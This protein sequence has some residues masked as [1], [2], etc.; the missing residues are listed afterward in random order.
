M[1]SER[2]ILYFDFIDPLSRLMAWELALPE[3]LGPDGFDWHPCE[4]RPPPTPLTTV[5]DA[6]VAERWAA[7]GNEDPL[8]RTWAPPVLVPWTRKAHEFM[9]HASEEG[10]AREAREAV[11]D[12]YLVEGRD[13]G[14]VDV[15]VAIG[16]SLGLDPG[17]TRPVLDV[18]R[19]GAEAAAAHEEAL[20]RGV[21]T[22]PTLVIGDRRLEGFHN[23]AAIRTFLG[24]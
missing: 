1:I 2:P 14:R 21:A 15:L 8:G 16:R 10:M 18:D 7:A 4:L 24:T 9:H 12:A 3:A 11:F 22:T 19:Y 17:E 5:D 23:A 13:I 6:E 20:G